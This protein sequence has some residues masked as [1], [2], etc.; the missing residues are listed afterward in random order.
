MKK[1]LP[2]II[3]LI[4]CNAAPDISAA[5]ASAEAYLNALK[6]DDFETANSFYSDEGS[7]SENRISKMKKLD[8]VMGNVVSYELKDSVI[9]SLEGEPAII[10]LTYQVKHEKLTSKELYTLRREEGK[11]L[12]INQLV[13]NWN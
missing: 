8:E 7:N 6:T 12:I 11:Y 4:S 1:L 3:L 10:N 9:S 13:E 2:I 5:R